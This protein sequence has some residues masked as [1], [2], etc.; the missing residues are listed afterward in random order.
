[1]SK[2]RFDVFLPGLLDE[3]LSND[4]CSVLK[5]PIN[6]T[7]RVLAELAKVAIEIDDPRLHVMMLRLGLYDVPYNKRVDEIKRL[8]RQIKEAGGGMARG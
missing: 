7:K 5:T 8:E 2:E 1:M 6:I 4:S 3:V